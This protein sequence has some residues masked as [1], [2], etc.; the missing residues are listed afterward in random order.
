MASETKPVVTYFEGVEGVKKIYMDTI[1]EGKEILAI[2]QPTKIDNHLEDWL[3]MTY[4]K[5][6]K[7]SG[8]GARVLVAG[9]E[10]ANDYIANDVEYLRETKIIPEQTYPLGHEINIYGS[11]IAMINNLEGEK[12]LGVIINNT[13][14]SQTFKSWFELTWI[15][16]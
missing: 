6:R 9:T 2:L 11:K 4:V 14:I 16:L 3:K 15:K 1:H 8:V 5:L 10:K 13:S 7:A 12:L